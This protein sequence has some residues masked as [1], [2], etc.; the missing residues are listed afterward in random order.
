MPSL[1]WLSGLA[2]LALALP[3]FSA[4]R[5]RLQYSP[6][7]SDE[8]FLIAAIQF[9][10]AQHGMV[11]GVHASLDGRRRKPGGF[12]TT[13][14]GRTWSPVSIPQMP[15]ALFFLNDR[16]GW[17]VG[18]EH[19]F[20]TVDFG[21]QWKRMGGARGALEVFFQD[22]NRGWTC[23][24]GKMVS[25]TLDGGAT[26]KP[27]PAAAEPKTTR[28]YTTYSTIAFANAQTATI[29][30]WSKKPSWNPG[31]T[32]R[33]ERPR[34]TP[35]VGVLVQTVD[36][37]AH[38][39]ADTVSMF[40]RITRIRL[41]P[42]GRGLGLIQFLDRFDWPSE[43]LR[44]D[45]RTGQSSR[46]F[47]QEDRAVTDMALVPGGPAYLAA[48]EPPGHLAHGPIPGKVKILRSDNIY[49]WTEM[50]V[51]YRA[52]ARRVYLAAPDPDHA[53]AATDTGMIFTLVRE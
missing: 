12:A 46:V 53:W 3:A 24:R 33:V 19:I 39:T 34:E 29:A 23:G 25:E 22:E 40:G 50:E 41:A 51:D 14:G 11:A 38:W 49:N 17:L 52:I 31:P 43:V 9:P 20:K 2:A 48:V 16:V 37:G 42:D 7:S 10:T 44:I 36:G 30:G 1:G 4:E 47:R 15:V 21:R 26:W 6:G 13:D 35:L 45:W 27:L 18:S 8:E 28:E 32:S 5:W